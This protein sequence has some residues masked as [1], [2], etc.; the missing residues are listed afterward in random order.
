MDKKDQIKR[1]RDAA[2]EKAANASSEEAANGFLKIAERHE[3]LLIKAIEGK[4]A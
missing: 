1:Y 2:L 4:Q 3:Q